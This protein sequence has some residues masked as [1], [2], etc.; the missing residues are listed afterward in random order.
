MARYD[1]IR[2]WFRTPRGRSLIAYHREDTSDWNTLN[3]CLGEVDEYQ[4]RDRHLAGTV[5]D[6][7]AHIGGVTLALL[8]D[9][10]DV[11]VIAVEPLPENV[12]LLRRNLRV[13]GIEDRC[14]IIE[15]AAGRSGERVTIS[16]A[17]DGGEHELHHA[18]IGNANTVP[19]D[20]LAHKAVTY[21]ARG[22][23][24]LVPEG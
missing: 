13:N 18:Y 11:H 24:D 21:V 14:T 2:A 23:V 19:P 5:L 15:G 17:F 16:Y 8:L 3:S 22:I 12:A 6:I 20:A 9:N 1:P 4:I 10:P 7:G